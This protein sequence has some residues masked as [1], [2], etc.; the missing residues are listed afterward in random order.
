MEFMTIVDRI[1]GKVARGRPPAYTHAHVLKAFETIGDRWQIGRQQLAMILGLGEGTVRTLIK[2]IRGQNLVS[3][4][5]GGITLTKSGVKLLSEL[6]SWMV[7]REVPE[8]VVAFGSRNYA[9]L[10]KQAADKVSRGIE[11][12]DAAIMAGAEGATTLIFDGTRLKMPGLAIDLDISLVSFI[13]TKLGP[14]TNDVVIVGFAD[15]QLSAEIGA[16]TA[17]LELLR[18]I[19]LLDTMSQQ[20]E[21]IQTMGREEHRKRRVEEEIVS[22]IRDK[23]TEYI[24]STLKESQEFEKIVKR[25]LNLEI[26]PYTAVDEIL[27]KM[28]K[29]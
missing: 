21:Y 29:R 4:S 23:A 3:V 22:V 17:A 15:D 5:R 6:R 28:I 16:R 10:V 1:T 26:D 13:L 8:T 25:V 12:R 14:E 19:E 24:L 18:K 11:Q 20:R 27:L 7:S 9:T 2:K